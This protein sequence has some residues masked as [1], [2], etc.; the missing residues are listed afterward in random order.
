MNCPKC[1]NE[2]APGKTFCT[3]CG[4]KLGGAPA[5]RPAPGPSLIPLGGEAAKPPEPVGPAGSSVSDIKK[6]IE[7]YLTGADIA[8]DDDETPVAAAA[9]GGERTSSGPSFFKTPKFWYVAGALLMVPALLLPWVSVAGRELWAWRIPAF[10]LLAMRSTALAPVSVGAL[11]FIVFCA[12]MYQALKR[13]RLLTAVRL[14]AG[15]A[16]ILGLLN[17]VGGIR[18]WNESLS[19]PATFAENSR[20]WI[21]SL[22]SA[23]KKIDLFIG[24]GG[25]PALFEPETKEAPAGFAFVLQY[26]RPGCLFAILCGI[27]LYAATFVF[28]YSGRVYRPALS[29]TPVAV[30]IVVLVPLIALL[31]LRFAFPGAWYR[32]EGAFWSTLGKSDKAIAAYETCSKLAVPP[33]TCPL[34]LGALYRKANRAPEAFDV[35]EDL[36]KKYPEAPQVNRALGDIHYFGKNYWRAAELFRKY[37][38]TKPDDPEINKKLAASL[39]YIGNESFVKWKREDTLRLFKEAMQLDPEYENN[40]GLHARIGAIYADKRQWA[41]AAPHFAKAAQLQPN[42]YEVQIEAAVAHV[43]IKQYQKAIEFYLQAIKTRPD[44]TQPYVALGDVYLNYMNDR[45]TAIE[46]YK[47]AVE[48]GDFTTE[49]KTA[50]LKLRRLGA[51]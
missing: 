6:E 36:S 51:L 4:T 40:S 50:K 12:V 22:D 9:A 14:G 30:G 10:A 7:K 43:R 41:E 47:K 32:I 45:N 39:V 49:G 13:G 17:I 28:P 15:V 33:M 46:W 42:E 44:F 8:P 37:R 48:I 24:R 16:L 26:C 3:K 23:Y 27:A 19:N 18:A 1:G 11:L 25:E 20:N 5:P 21:L 34:K 2:I 38:K 35:L 31:V 29:A